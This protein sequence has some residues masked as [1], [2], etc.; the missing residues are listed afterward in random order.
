M[1][2][3]SPN[4]L[5]AFPTGVVISYQSI[6]HNMRV[7][8]SNQSSFQ[9]EQEISKDTSLSV[10][11]NH[12]RAMHIP[13]VHG[14]NVPTCT[15]GF[16]LCRPNL[17][18]GNIDQYA[19]EGDSW[20]DAMTL[21]VRARPTKWGTARLSYTW[22]H[23][24]DDLGQSFQLGPTVQNN[25]RADRGNSDNDQRHRLV[26]SGETHTPRGPASSVWQHVSHGFT[27]SGDFSYGSPLPLN[28]VT[29]TDVN[30][31]S[32]VNDRPVGAGRNVLRGF[33]SQSTNGRVSRTFRLT[34]IF[35]L[36]ALVEGFNLLN[37]PNYLLPNTT[38]GTGLFPQNPRS[39]F[40]QPTAV[41]DSRQ[42]QIA[43]RLTF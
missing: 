40:G 16:D 31:D 7:D 10:G 35:T 27:L 34:E 41:G 25:V 18:Y 29:G 3:C 39:G 37:H 5:P 2:P 23:T 42:L 21:S 24:I 11:Y 28:A 32:Y 33:D 9:A 4:I 43:V 6:E 12:L 15:T 1:H 30:G 22:S 36:Q 17:Q 19:G 13:G 20:Y 14:T 8:S 38:F 26:L